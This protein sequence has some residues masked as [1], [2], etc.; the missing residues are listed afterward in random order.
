MSRLSQTHGRQSLVSPGVAVRMMRPMPS[1]F[2]PRLLASLS[3]GLLP[4]LAAAPA[5]AEDWDQ[6]PT[7]GNGVLMQT[8]VPVQAFS[9]IRVQAPIDIELGEGPTDGAEVHVDSN[10]ASRVRLDVDRGVLTVSM[11][12]QSHNLHKRSRIVLR[13]PSIEAITLE[14]SADLKVLRRRQKSADVKLTLA[15]SGDLDWEHGDGETLDAVLT[16]SGDLDIKGSFRSANINV[17]GSGDVEAKA[18]RVRDGV[19]LNL[20]G[21]GDVTLE[22][23]ALSVNAQV[24]GSGDLT[25][26][27]MCGDTLRAVVSGSGDLDADE[28]QCRAAFVTTQGSGDAEVLVIAGGRLVLEAH[29]SGTIQWSDGA[30]KG[31][32]GGRN[33]T[34]RREP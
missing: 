30:Q 29:G 11:V 12:G 2:R 19:Q 5:L 33:R 27:G 10:L 1:S 15:G 18:F 16:G 21:S 26:K 23:G 22:G 34:F 4:M 25:V 8:H 32:V 9:S 13:T 6:V 20:Q 28:F 14:S 7:R 17:S 24:T 31:T 3:F